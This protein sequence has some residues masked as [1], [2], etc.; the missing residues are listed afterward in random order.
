M[1]NWIEIFRTGKHTD[2]K[3]R[4]RVWTEAD[5]DK[6]VALYNPQNHEAPVVI[7]HPTSNGPAFGW[8]E[9][10][11][12]VG[13]KLMAKFKQ[14]Q[15]EFSE[16][17][18]KGL[19]K[20]RSAS[21]YPGGSLRHVGFLGAQPPA[22][23][24]LA[25]IA[26]NDGDDCH[27]YEEPITEEVNDMTKEQQLEQQLADERQK[28]KAAEAE[29][30]K[31]KK[32]AETNAASFAEAQATAAKKEI[33]DFIETGIK[34]GKILPAWKDQGLA[35]FMSALDEN[36]GE[37]EFAEGKKQSPSAWFRDFLEGFSAHPLFKDMVR[38]NGDG[39]SQEDA[40]FEEADKLADEIAAYAGGN[41][42]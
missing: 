18:D 23:K 29:A 24:G 4:E 17:V 28:R 39:K 33:N 15:P 36:D 41:D 22:I 11:K 10:L 13:G 40:E 31:Y 16:W 8:V 32:E 5:L 2:S 35:D 27:E 1:N 21:F 34:E 3:G 19:Y 12:R 7:G 14:V 26:F 42:E 6:T 9:Q 25:D 20:K 38:P 37:Y 30:G